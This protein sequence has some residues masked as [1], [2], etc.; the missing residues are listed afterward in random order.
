M[1]PKI[2]IS[3]KSI[4]LIALIVIANDIVSMIVD[5]RMLR[6]RALALDHCHHAFGNSHCPPG[7]VGA[8]K[9]LVAHKCLTLT[10]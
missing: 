9:C 4:Y 7:K 10:S 3:K 2:R 5:A 6:E 1:I 8:M